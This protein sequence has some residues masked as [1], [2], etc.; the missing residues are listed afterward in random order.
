MYFRSKM[1]FFFVI[2]NTQINMNMMIQVIYIKKSL[3]LI[4]NNKKKS[5]AAGTLPGDSL[6]GEQVSDSPLR[7]GW[8]LNGAKKSVITENLSIKIC[9]IYLFVYN[10]QF[11]T[12]IHRLI[13]CLF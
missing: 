4:N 6:S 1:C 11:T 13:V 10:S 5:P 7:G 3:I 9:L 12:S 8:G 2:K